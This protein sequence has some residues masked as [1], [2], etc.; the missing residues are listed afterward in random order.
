VFF[1]IQYFSTLKKISNYNACCVVVNAAIVEYSVRVNVM[2]N[3]FGDFD[4]F[5]RKNHFKRF[6]VA[7]K[8]PEK[9]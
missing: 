5:L 4:H 9:S 7:Q 8:K 2:I 3:I 1:T 6:S